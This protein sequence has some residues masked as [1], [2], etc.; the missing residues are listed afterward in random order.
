MTV[1][2]TDIM[3]GPAQSTHPR[4]IRAARVGE[5]ADQLKLSDVAPKF[6]MTVEELCKLTF[7]T[8]SLQECEEFLEE[9][10]GLPDAV[11]DSSVSLWVFKYDQDGNEIKAVEDVEL[12][13]TYFEPPARRPPQV[14]PT[15]AIQGLGASPVRNT[16]DIKFK[17]GDILLC[18]HAGDEFIANMSLAWP[19]HAGIVTDGDNDGAT[20]AMPGKWRSETGWAGD[21]RSLV[22][23]NLPVLIGNDAF[24][25]E[26]ITPSGGLVYRYKGG[27]QQAMG[28]KRVQQ[29]NKKRRKGLGLFGFLRKKDKAKVVETE[30]NREMLARQVA[31]AAARWA[32]SQV[33]RNYKFNLRSNIIGVEGPRHT[34]RRDEHGGLTTPDKQFSMTKCAECGFKKGSAACEEL[35]ELLH[36]YKDKTSVKPQPGKLLCLK[37]GQLDTTHLH[38]CDTLAE[39]CDECGFHE[40]SWACKYFHKQMERLTDEGE[41]GD[42]WFYTKNQVKD[43]LGAG[44]NDFLCMSCGELWGKDKCCQGG[45]TE[46]VDEDGSRRPYH[47]KYQGNV[48]L[49]TPAHSIYCSEFV[50]RAYRFGGGVTLV[51]PKEFLYFYKHPNRA[52]TW[53]LWHVSVKDKQRADLLR[54]VERWRWVPNAI[55]RKVLMQ[56]HFKG[57]YSGYILAPVQLA[58]SKFVE[59]VHRVPAKEGKEQ[60]TVHNVHKK[61]IS[62]TDVAKVLITDRGVLRSLRYNKL[63]KDLLGGTDPKDDTQFEKWLEKHVRETRRFEKWLVDHAVEEKYTADSL[64]KPVG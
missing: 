62:P 41:D 61:N 8:G 7:G 25:D 4:G 42:D 9:D 21:G 57:E 54:K 37:C 52:T 40:D 64:D 11:L 58:Q 12:G 29:V 34:V 39:E 5:F 3:A 17:N 1:T 63:M 32:R 31:E 45:T 55:L 26:G 24:F 35:D 15:G 48:G 56:W 10:W 28:N 13:E 43:K 19:T 60:I 59:K 33:G 53:L 46:L 16:I 23:D 20:D 49:T 14:Q 2:N 6:G 18:H 44:S 22:V 30:A 47:F 51:E 50:W 36:E 27:G 38:V